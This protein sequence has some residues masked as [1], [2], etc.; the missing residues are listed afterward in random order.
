MP[1]FKSFDCIVK[2]WMKG[3]ED[4]VYGG[5]LGGHCSIWVRERRKEFYSNQWYQGW[6]TNVN[7]YKK[8][9]SIK[10]DRTE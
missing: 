9:L 10:D 8:Y 7:R 6:Q 3:R 4:D 5:L 1:G 2:K